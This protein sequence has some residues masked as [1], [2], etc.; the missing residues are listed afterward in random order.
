V[1]LDGPQRRDHET[2]ESEH[3]AN[4]SQQEAPEEVA[5]AEQPSANFVENTTTEQIYVT[6]GTTVNY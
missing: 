4:T 2:L 1:E 6:S 5:I 3:N